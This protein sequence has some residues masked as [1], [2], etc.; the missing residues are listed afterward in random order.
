M[1]A[2][3]RTRVR[4]AG[5]ELWHEVVTPEGVPLVFQVARVGERAG[6]FVLDLLIQG[7]VTVVL[8]ILVLQAVSTGGG[9]WASAFFYLFFFVLRVFY[10]IWFELRWQ[11]ATPG[12]RMSGIR[13]MDAQGGPL[14]ADSVFVRN[15][16][17]ELEIFLPLTLL[18]GAGDIPVWA[19]LVSA[20]WALVFTFMPLFNRQRLRVGDMVAGTR[21][22]V[23][24]KEVLLPD[25]GGQE[26]R[27]SE[28]N[29]TQYEFTDSQLGVYG[30]Y[31]LQVL[32]D[33]LRQPKGPQRRQALDAVTHRIRRKVVWTGGKVKPERF[34][35][36]FY[37]AL[38]ARL[39]QK[40]LLGKRKKDKYSKE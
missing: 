3:A 29:K 10:F 20:V 17:R 38:R 11:G 12:K 13:V 7:V 28:Q 18:F 22:V 24:P 8:T 25:L 14:R 35:R 39:E 31:E 1:S 34:L 32:E 6:A 9:D 33:L 26:V 16:M 36:E 2:T 4:G 40:M 30:I 19:R 21:V 27:R 15:V 37:A 23:T 5:L